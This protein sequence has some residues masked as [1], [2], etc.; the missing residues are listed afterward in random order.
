MQWRKFEILMEPLFIERDAA[1]N[2]CMAP[3]QKIRAR[4]KEMAGHLFVLFIHAV[5]GRS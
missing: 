4:L 3:L 5:T 1:T 2:A